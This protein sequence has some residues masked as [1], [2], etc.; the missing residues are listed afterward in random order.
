MKILIKNHVWSIFRRFAYFWS[1]WGPLG[2]AKSKKFQ[3]FFFSKCPKKP[4]KQ[5]VF[6]RISIFFSKKKSRF[7]FEKVRTFSKKNFFEN[8]FRLWKFLDFIFWKSAK[9]C[10]NRQK[11]ENWRI[12]SFLWRFHKKIL[13]NKKVRSLFVKM[14]KKEKN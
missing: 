5:L 11:R 1:F 4:K 13:K 8:W 7:F 12:S 6:L 10:K 3:I 14:W 2:G 9:M